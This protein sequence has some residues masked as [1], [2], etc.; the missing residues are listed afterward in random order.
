MITLDTFLLTNTCLL[1]T[2]KLMKYEMD[3]FG[4]VKDRLFK[5]I[6]LHIRATKNNLAH[7]SPTR[8]VI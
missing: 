1:K 7:A 4:Q 2:L 5:N 8:L 6:H 3:K